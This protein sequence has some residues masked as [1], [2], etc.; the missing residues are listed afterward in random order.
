MKTYCIA[1]WKQSGSLDSIHE[2]LSLIRRELDVALVNDQAGSNS[3]SKDVEFIFCPPHP[4]IAFADGKCTGTSIKIGAQLCSSASEK[5]STGDVSAAMLADVGAKFV[6]IGHSEARDRL[7]PSE[8]DLIAQLNSALDA[9][10]TPIFCIGESDQ[11][12]SANKTKDH[13]TKQ[14]SILKRINTPSSILIA[15]EPI[16]AIGTGKTAKPKEIQDTCNWIAEHVSDLLS[17]I[18]DE[19]IPVLYGGSVKPENAKEIMNLD[20]INGVLVGGASLDA[21]KMAQIYQA[22]F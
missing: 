13:L 2:Y 12:R 9:G 11:T 17:E 21:Q 8:E 16:W 4:Y 5:A 19:I 7:K 22:G 1:N 15:Y 20:A 18:L 10:L 14:L 3:G 6:I